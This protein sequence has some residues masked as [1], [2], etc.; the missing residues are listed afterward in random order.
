MKGAIQP[1]L[2]AS[3]ADLE[4]VDAT[5]VVA[6]SFAGMNAQAITAALDPV[7]DAS[8]ADVDFPN[9]TDQV[10]A[11]I[12]GWSA[13][14]IADAV[15]AAL[16]A[17][18]EVD[19]TDEGAEARATFFD[20][21]STPQSGNRAV[22]TINRQR[23]RR[24]HPTPVATEV[25]PRCGYRIGASVLVRVRTSRFESASTC[26]FSHRTISRTVP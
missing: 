2:F 20:G 12:R 6:E 3:F 21:L 7:L 18:I 17:N 8:F 15:E 16:T 26:T 9:L 13:S 23:S 22:A 24:R 25:V 14:E 5:P 10:I 19:L 4:P 11:S 1:A